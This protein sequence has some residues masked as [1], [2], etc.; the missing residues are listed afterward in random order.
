[1]KIEN[2]DDENIEVVFYESTENRLKRLKR[3]MKRKVQ[4]NFTSTLTALINVTSENDDD[5]VIFI[6]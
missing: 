5:D 2:K 3:L 4:L 6:N 1:M